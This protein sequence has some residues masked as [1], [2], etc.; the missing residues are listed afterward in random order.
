MAELHNAEL[1]DLIEVHRKGKLAIAEAKEYYSQLED[2]NDHKPL[3]F[4]QIQL[5][6]GM[7]ELMEEVIRLRKVIDENNL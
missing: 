4:S 1:K 2:P 6:D 3:I 5:M 7:S